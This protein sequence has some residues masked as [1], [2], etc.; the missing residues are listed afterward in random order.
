MDTIEAR[1][2]VMDEKISVLG[3]VIEPEEAVFSIQKIETLEEFLDNEETLLKDPEAFKLQVCSLLVT[4][5]GSFSFELKDSG[6]RMLY[7]VASELVFFRNS[8]FPL[9]FHK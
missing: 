1:M 2:N 8:N 3:R 9:K 4:I 6:I 5:D 7:S